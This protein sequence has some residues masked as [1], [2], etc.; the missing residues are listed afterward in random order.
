M[1]IS[2]SLSAAGVQLEATALRMFGA[3]VQQG[4]MGL[5]GVGLRNNVPSP[6]TISEQKI[7]GDWNPTP[8]ASALASS[9]GAFD[10]KT[11]FLFKVKFEFHQE[12]IAAIAALGIDAQSLMRDLTFVVKN[13]DLPKIDYQY[14][15]VNMYNFR[16]KV[17]KS[18]VWSDT[19]VSF[20]DDVGNRALGFFNLYM[21]LLKP[22]SRS[23][24]TKDMRLEDFGFEFSSSYADFDAS[25]RGVL[26]NNRKEVLS[27][28]TIEQ[29]YVDRSAAIIDAVKMNSFI[30]TNPRI[31]NMSMAGLDHAVGSD[32]A[33]INATFDFDSVHIDMAG[34]AKQHRSPSLP[35]ADLLDGAEDTAYSN[36]K[37]QQGRGGDRY[38]ATIARS[39]D[40]SSPTIPAPLLLSAGGAADV[41]EISGALD[42]AAAQTRKSISYGVSQGLARPTVNYVSDNS[43]DPGAV[44]DLT[45][46]TKSTDQ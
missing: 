32:G 14:E 40:R 28:I 19:S 22:I 30:F 38:A 37:S 1:D 3:A 11:R 26:P 20:H 25:Y 8:Y 10:P 33:S 17:L 43:V 13:I 2:N 15:E 12:L 27:K 45:S 34:D 29:F 7:T 31:H 36:V 39:S 41:G 16:T 23:V 24:P 21:M 46:R 44:P 35:G 9:A 5:S 42:I 18:I 6:I 4:G